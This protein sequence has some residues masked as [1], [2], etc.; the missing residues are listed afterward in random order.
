MELARIDSDESKLKSTD[1]KSLSEG[2]FQT[3]FVLFF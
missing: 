3:D 2:A 1:Q